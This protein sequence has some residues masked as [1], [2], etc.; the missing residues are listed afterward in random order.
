M[1]FLLW[2][3]SVTGSLAGLT[4]VVLSAVPTISAAQTPER[5]TLAGNDVAV[6]NIAGIMRVEGGTGSEVTV[7][8][9]RSGGDASRLQIQ[10]GSIRGRETLRVVYPDRRIV[11]R[12]PDSDR[13]RGRTTIRVDDDG[14]FGDNHNDDG[15]S[16]DIVGSGDGL[17]AHADIRVVVP[18]GKRLSVYLGVGEAKI[19]NVEGDLYVDVSAAPVTTTHTRGKLSLDTG[20][21]EVRVTDAQGEIDL[22]TGS[23]SVEVANIKGPFLKM[24]TGSGRVRATDVVVDE[25]ELD[26]GSGSVRLGQVQSKRIKLDSGSGSVELDLRA[27]VETLHVESGSGGVTLGIPESLGASIRIETGSGGIDTDIPVQVRKTERNFLSGTIGDGKGEITIETGS[28][29]VRLRR[30]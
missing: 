2:S 5:R 8:I 18:R 12:Q 6:Y 7:E 26:T 20:S 25:L 21:G 13:W 14:T 1:R 30:S 27:D 29:G 9:T 17:D 10:S 15:R 19:E 4:A 24:D 23:G 3:N 16:V 11:Y 22:D 28:G